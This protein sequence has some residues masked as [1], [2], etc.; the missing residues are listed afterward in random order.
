MLRGL[1]QSRSG[2]DHVAAGRVAEDERRFPERRRRGIGVCVHRLH[3]PLDLAVDVGVAQADVPCVVDA[4]GDVELKPGNRGLADV[5]QYRK[6][7]RLAV[8]HR[9]ARA[10]EL[11][12]LPVDREERDVG[13]HAVVHAERLQAD[14]EAR[15]ALL[16]HKQVLSR[17]ALVAV[18]GAGLVAPGDVCVHEEIFAGL[19]L[20][21]QFGKERV[22]APRHGRGSPPGGDIERV[23]VVPCLDADG[24]RVGHR[25]LHGTEQGG[26][27]DGLFA[28]VTKRRAFVRRTG[29]DG[30]RRERGIEWGE[31]SRSV[32][33]RGGRGI[34]RRDQLSGVLGRVVVGAQGVVQARVCLVPQPEFLG[35]VV[36][37]VVVGCE[38]PQP[39]VNP[40]RR[41]SEPLHREGKTH[42]HHR[43]ARVPAAEGLVLGGF[44]GHVVVARQRRKGRVVADVGIDAQPEP[45]ALPGGA[46][47]I[48]KTG[49]E[50]GA[51]VAAAVLEHG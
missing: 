39:R 9:R 25:K 6:R 32:D 18:H 3:E 50:A 10:G 12:V 8:H 46:R 28:V 45:Q 20:R 17:K 38:E 4:R 34:E 27:L 1:R 23:L 36:E 44:R 29:G 33:V 37:A 11:H 47:K 30:R 13:L 43:Q 41:G 16:V 15:R 5:L 7:P 31:Y 19:D 49:F 2:D 48:E 26:A 24:E 22:E 42:A 40:R 14:F 51:P 35:K 21:R